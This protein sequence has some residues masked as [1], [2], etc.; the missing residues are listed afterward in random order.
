[1]WGGVPPQ[2]LGRTSVSEEKD[3]VEK[4]F[5][6]FVLRNVTIF[7]YV[8]AG[9]IGEFTSLSLGVCYI[10]R[11]RSTLKW[12]QAEGW[13]YTWEK[14]N[15]HCCIIQTKLFSVYS[16]HINKICVLKKV[17]RKK[18]HL[19]SAL[20]EY[21]DFYKKFHN[22]KFNMSTLILIWVITDTKKVLR[23]VFHMSKY[24]SL[25]SKFFVMMIF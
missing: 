22:F 14:K 1:M 24:H 23:I 12:L 25:A 2:H 17:T 7:Q 8:F 15:T 4:W 21:G 6:N 5:R 9:L 13:K 18:K 10:T 19:V 3:P 11:R 16:S 20:K